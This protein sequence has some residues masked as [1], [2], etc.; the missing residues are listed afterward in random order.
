MRNSCT[1]SHVFRKPLSLEQVIEQLE[2]LPDEA[3]RPPVSVPDSP[4]KDTL[5]MKREDLG[6]FTTKGWTF[7]AGKT[8]PAESDLWEKFAPDEEV[9]STLRDGWKGLHKVEIAPAWFEN[10]ANDEEAAAT[11]QQE[12]TAMWQAGVVQPITKEWVRTYGPPDVLIPHFMVK[13][14]TKYRVIADARY[15]NVA[16]EPPWFHMTSASAQ[17]ST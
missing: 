3:P 10:Y 16:Q 6:V 13:E 9:K 8:L 5:Q 17:V 4:L 11:W 1:E 15:P 7:K 12:H 14:A 2:A